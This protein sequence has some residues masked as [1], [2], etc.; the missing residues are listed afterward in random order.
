MKIE[1]HDMSIEQESFIT[2]WWERHQRSSI[3]TP[4]KLTLTIKGVFGGHAGE[5]V[6]NIKD[7]GFV[8]LTYSHD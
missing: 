5:L 6:A 2:S 7:M 8:F 4:S 3:A 1:T